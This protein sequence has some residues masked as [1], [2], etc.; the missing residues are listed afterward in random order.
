MLN[1]LVLTNRATKYFA[2]IGIT[3]SAFECRATQAHC[4]TGNQDALRI[5]AVQD[6]A[7]AFA[8][9]SDA[10]FHGDAQTVNE[11]LI[12]VNALAAQLFDFADFNLAAIHVGVEQAQTFRTLAFFDWCRAREQQYFVGHLSRADPDFLAVNDIVVAFTHCTCLEFQRV[13]PGIGFCHTEASPVRT[14]NQRGQPALLL[15]V[16]AEHHDGVQA[17]NIHVDRR[18]TGQT[19]TCCRNRMHHERRFT[20]AQACTAVRLGHSDTQP[21][22]LGQRMVK[23]IRKTAF[24]VLAQPVVCIEGRADTLNGVADLFLI[25]GTGEVHWADPFEMVLPGRITLSGDSP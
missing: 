5:Q 14:C 4:F 9:F 24:L 22:R 3:C 18:G 17:K 20:D 10:V 2:L 11:H 21:A 16:G 1:T 15:L 25:R 13:E 12:G 7:E 8:F 6:V 23:I 19:G